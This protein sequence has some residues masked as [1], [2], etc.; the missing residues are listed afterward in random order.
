MGRDLARQHV[1]HLGPQDHNFP[2][3][4]ESGTTARQ[5]RNWD[6]DAD[7]AGWEDKDGG[8]GGGSDESRGVEGDCRGRGRS[9]GNRARGLSGEMSLGWERMGG[10]EERVYNFGAEQRKRRRTY[11][12]YCTSW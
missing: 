9:H 4:A 6:G 7:G 12:T 3:H 11:T 8:C 5:G 1:S 2:L 10:I